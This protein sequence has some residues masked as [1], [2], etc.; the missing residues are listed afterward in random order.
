EPELGL[1][2]AIASVSFGACRTLVFRHKRSK[3]VFKVDLSD[4]SLLLMS[5]PT[6]QNWTHGINKSTRPAGP[7]VNL[8]FRNM[9]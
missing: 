7:R 5:G 9:V 2:P 8:T 4:G 6:Q 1:A 3:Q